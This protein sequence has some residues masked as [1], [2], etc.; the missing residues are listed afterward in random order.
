[1]GYVVNIMPC[2]LYLQDTVPL[3][4]QY[5]LNIGYSEK[6]MKDTV[7]TNFLGLQTDTWSTF[8]SQNDYSYQQYCHTS[9]DFTDF[10]STMNYKVIW[11]VICPS[12]TGHVRNI[13]KLLVLW[14]VQNLEISC[15]SPYTNYTLPHP[16]TYKYH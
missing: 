1:M 10:H 2:P 8:C 9:N 11:A 3:P 13:I 5:T 15:T 7:N 4:L 14:M 6:H 12:Q 16:Q